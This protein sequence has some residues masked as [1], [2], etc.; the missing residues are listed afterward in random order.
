M[1]ASLLAKSIWWKALLS[2][3]GAYLLISL[4]VF[5]GQRK[6]I[7]HPSKLPVPLPDGFQTW[8]SPDRSELWGYKR[9]RGAR[10]CLFFFHGNGG[11]ASGWS[12]AVAEFPGDIFVLEYPGYGQRPGSPSE[13]TLKE[14]ALKAF[15]AEHH[16][17]AKIILAGQSLGAAITHPIFTRHPDRISR[18]VLITPFTSIADV[19]RAH[20]PWL[21]TRW[22]L[23]DT[24][25]LFEDWQKFPGQSCIVLAGR[26]EVI[27]SSHNLQ[28][29]NAKSKACEIVELPDDSHNTIDLDKSF[30]TRLLTP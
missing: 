6:L 16:N 26:D 27:P 11:N 5:L 13:K 29:R 17:Y 20:Y 21:P 7:Y 24:M 10:E 25:H 15:T 14:A 18:L 30:W 22:M 2:A 19:A 12:H 1:L 23:R 9:T 8:H 3:A 4:L 28:Y